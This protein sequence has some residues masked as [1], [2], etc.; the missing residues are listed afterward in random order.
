[1][2]KAGLSKIEGRTRWLNGENVLLKNKNISPEARQRGMAQRGVELTLAEY[3][4]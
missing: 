4:W 3:N 1:M 2:I